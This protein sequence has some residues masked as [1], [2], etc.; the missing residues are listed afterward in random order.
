[1]S[2]INE[3]MEMMR[4]IIKNKDSYINE[5]VADNIRLSN[6]LLRIKCFISLLIVAGVF[7]Y[8]IVGLI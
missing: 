2:D 8:S 5:L 6:Q 7:A 4:T 1:M 3:C